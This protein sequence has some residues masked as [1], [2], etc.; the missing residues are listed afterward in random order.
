MHVVNFE[1]CQAVFFSRISDRMPGCPCRRRRRRPPEGDREACWN[2]A[3]A[4]GKDLWHG[5][6]SPHRKRVVT[7]DG[8]I[9]IW[10][11]LLRRKKREMIGASLLELKFLDLICADSSPFPTPTPMPNPQV[12]VAEPS[13]AKKMKQTLQKYGVEKSIYDRG[14]TEMKLGRP[15][16]EAGVVEAIQF[17]D[18]PN[19]VRQMLIAMLPEGICVPADQRHEYQNTHVKM[20][21]ELLQG[22]LSKLQDGVTSATGEVAR[23]EAAKTELL[24]KVQEAVDALE[25]ANDVES[26]TKGNLAEVTR[27]VLTCKSTLADKEKERCEGDAAHEAAKEEKLVIEQ[28]L[29]EE[30]RVLRDG[31]VEGEDAKAHYKKLEALAGK[32]GFEASLMTALP[33]SILKKPADRGSFDA[34]V[35]GLGKRLA[36]LNE[37]IQTGAPASAERLASVEKA[38]KDLEMAKLKQQDEEMGKKW[39]TFYRSMGWWIFLGDIEDFR[40][41]TEVADLYLSAKQVQKD[42]QGAKKAADTKVKQSEPDLKAAKKIQQE[43]E[44]RLENYK[45]KN[46]SSFETLRDRT[47]TKE[48]EAGEVRMLE[49]AAAIEA[50]EAGA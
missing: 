25:K 3:R 24:T 4:R 39:S 26:T 50:A 43:A 18:V 40:A 22:V 35:E 19:S 48:V 49:E 6:L 44:N 32:I 15:S 21:L 16:H 42:C 2:H 7:V 14:P 34:M 46:W 37:T 9:S 45:T 33:T 29:A 41:E 10:I 30:F 20:I 47:C 8:K 31:E 28:A 23:I 11:P 13:E 38:K 17:A 36:Q 27:T 12:A 5:R 1:Y